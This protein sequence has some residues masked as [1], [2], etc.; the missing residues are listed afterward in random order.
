MVLRVSVSL[1]LM[2]PRQAPVSDVRCLPLLRFDLDAPRLG[3]VL[4]LPPLVAVSYS[5]ICCR[6]LDSI[7]LENLIELESIK[8]LVLDTN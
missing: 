7:P 3:E 8:I 1:T 4:R 6:D 2:D 5:V